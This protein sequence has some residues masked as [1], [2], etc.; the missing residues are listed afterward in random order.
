MAKEILKD[1]RLTDEQ[2]DGVAGGTGEEI[3]SDYYLMHALAQQG[4]VKFDTNANPTKELE[5]AWAK[6]GIS[7]ILHDNDELNEYYN[8]DGKQISRTEARKHVLSQT[9][10]NLDPNV[11]SY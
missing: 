4:A 10:C 6:F 2:L 8:S 9:N 11:I 3:N 7:V 5:R 1:E